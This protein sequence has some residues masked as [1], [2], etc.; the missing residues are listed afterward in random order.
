MCGSDPRGFPLQDVQRSRWI[1]GQLKPDRNREQETVQDADA[2]QGAPSSVLPHK[3]AARRLSGLREIIEWLLLLCHLQIHTT[4]VGAHKLHPAGD[5]GSL[6]NASPIERW[7]LLFCRSYAQ[8]EDIWD[9]C[10]HT[11]R[12]TPV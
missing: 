8:W 4:I 6:W 12:H 9:G 5:H 2:L 10:T 11:G 1:D 7:L 3:P